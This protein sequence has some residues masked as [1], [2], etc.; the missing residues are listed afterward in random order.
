M[1][2]DNPQLQL[3]YEKCGKALEDG[4]R[5]KPSPPPP[6]NVYAVTFTSDEET[7]KRVLKYIGELPTKDRSFRFYPAAVGRTVA[8]DVGT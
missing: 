3:A 6:M 1:E 5:R 8:K 2:F 4:W 7:A